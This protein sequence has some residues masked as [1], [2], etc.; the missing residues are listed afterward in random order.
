M[1]ARRLCVELTDTRN[2]RS[3]YNKSG[4]SVHVGRLS[5]LKSGL[6]LASGAGLCQ[7]RVENTG[8][9]EGGGGGEGERGKHVVKRKH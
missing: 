2:F 4:P 8:K 1:C 5:N 7:R 9:G 6:H 3:C